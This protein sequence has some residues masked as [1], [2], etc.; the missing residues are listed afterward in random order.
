MLLAGLLAPPID[1][2]AQVAVQDEGVKGRKTPAANAPVSR[3]DLRAE[4]LRAG[5]AFLVE[6]PHRT[7]WN[8][9]GASGD[10]CAILYGIFSCDVSA[11]ENARRRAA[12]AE[13]RA[14]VD[15]A[16]IRHGSAMIRLYPIS[17]H[18]TKEEQVIFLARLAEYWRLADKGL[19]PALQARLSDLQGAHRLPVLAALHAVGDVHGTKEMAA[20]DE[21][22]ATVTHQL[23]ILWRSV[24]AKDRDGSS[25]NSEEKAQA[26]RS[27]R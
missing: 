9:G 7:G 27:M 14:L 19:L 23:G 16:A 11:L 2:V 5:F 8:A 4:T 24:N 1:A 26:A 15:R 25:T 18:A 6:S 21:A 17:E 12:D 13:T 3:E 10:L 20:L 22:S